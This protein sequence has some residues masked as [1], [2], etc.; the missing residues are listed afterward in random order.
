M[1][2]EKIND[3]EYTLSQTS[4]IAIVGNNRSYSENPTIVIPEM[5][6]DSD[7]RQYTVTEIVDSAFYGNKQIRS[8]T[9]MNGVRHL[10]VGAFQ[11][12][13]SLATVSVSSSIADWRESV[14][15]ECTSLKSV[16]IE[17]G[18]ESIGANTFYQC[19]S[20]ASV[21][22]PGSVE[23][24]GDYA[25][26]ECTSLES[27]TMEKGVGGIG[28][29][30]FSQ[31]SSLASVT[32]PGSVDSIG[33]WAFQYCT[34][35]KS[36]TIEKGVRSIRSTAFGDCSSLASVTIPGSVD[37]I[38]SW[39]FQHCTSLKSVTIEEGVRRIADWVF[40]KNSSLASVTLPNSLRSIGEYAFGECLKLKDVYLNWGDPAGRT[41]ANN[42]F[43]WQN[44]PKDCKIHIP[45][46][47]EEKYGWKN[48]DS[49]LTWMEFPIV[50][51]D[52]ELIVEVNDSTGGSAGISRIAADIKRDRDFGRLHYGNTRTEILTAVPNKDCLF[53]EWRTGADGR[54]L[55]SISPYTFTYTI[56]SD[57][58][59][60]ANFI[61]S[62]YQVNLSAAANGTIKSG[63]DKYGYNTKATIEA[64]ADTGYHFLKW[65]NK[66]GDNLST[67]NPYTFIVT[68]DM[69]IQ[70][71]FAVNSYN[72]RLSA[73]ANGTIKSG[74]NV[75]D[76]NTEAKA[77]AKANYG[78]HFWKWTNAQGD[79]LS[80]SN[81]YT[82]IVK[83][84]T[85]I[86]ANF[87]PNSYQVTLSAD[88]NGTIKAG[89]GACLYNTSAKVQAE[90]N[91]GYH[92]L[93]WTNA[94]GNS[95]STANPYTFIVKGDT[96]IQAHFALNSYQVTLS[97]NRNGRIKSGGE[98]CLYNAET[99]AE[100]EADM[101]YH[102][103]KWTN[104]KG[105][106]VSGDN[107]YRF[108]VK[109]DTAVQAHFA[110]NSYPVRLSA[111]NGTIKSVIRSIY[112]YNTGVKVEAEANEGYHFV[113]WTDAK[114]DSVSGDNPYNL[115]VKGET[116]VKARFVLNDG[117]Q[118]SLS[119][120][121]NGTVTQGN[122]TY[123]HGATA[124]V[125]AT[126][127]T[128][129]HFVKW[130]NAMGD[131]LSIANP[132]TFV[133]TGDTAVQAHFAVNN[134]SVKLSAQN[135]RIKAGGG[136]YAY[137]TEAEVEAGEADDGYHFVMWG[138]AA[139][140]QISFANPYR[141]VVKEE[142]ALTAWFVKDNS[143]NGY[144]VSLSADGNGMITSGDGVYL[145]GAEVKI[146]A[147]AH[148]GY[149]FVKWTKADGSLFSAANPY[150]FIATEDVV[151]TAVFEPLTGFQT[152]SGVEEAGV[153]YAEGVLH[154]ANLE[155]Y[156]ISVSTMKGER[157]LQFTAGGD[158]AEQA[159]ALSA[160]VYILNGAKWKEK[161]VARKFVVK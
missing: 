7:G 76:Y 25:F 34:S 147:G 11:A 71:H 61:R 87:A 97:A 53:T 154:L 111:E 157:V 117:Y 1:E 130:A 127:D 54:T 99:R 100:A 94:R 58:I 8:V 13:Q 60:T 24:V 15:R 148:E 153:Y 92:F 158:D 38:G 82:F 156:F 119:A 17:K 19:S 12:C 106:S 114:G 65:T 155:G 93:E 125:T 103:V 73:A 144:K 66:Q 136:E 105:D 152:L 59:V 139:G 23:S 150:T 45:K 95:L 88:N 2:A 118:V 109:G 5:V 30:A 14:F 133:V 63:A 70:A 104:A 112:P 49:Q 113:K 74:T 44:K 27:V 40:F 10:G 4:L 55:S 22:I 42:L 46:Y 80:A 123:A 41:V 115:I 68:R 98:P 160:G 101:G 81:P 62:Y 116:D 52:Y 89:G 128:G 124:T 137:N 77:E 142:T 29:Y 20:L 140:K 75:C 67:A 83:G 16:T 33:S 26:Q 32:I 96:A 102:F 131:K 43:F 126:A 79:S 6:T 90:A 36:L 129:Y 39:A 31:C 84:D 120:A 18:I 108:V 141:F 159:A 72:V 143:S 51:P 57:T 132:Y 48:T 151:L 56:K 85:A 134:Y 3:V 47:S 149:R 21:T 145:P 35:L 9:I 86:R 110:I 135:G 64:K 122:R 161:F 37:N 50:L 146:E 28:V 78:Y 91:Y 107:P 121:D 138:N 69:D